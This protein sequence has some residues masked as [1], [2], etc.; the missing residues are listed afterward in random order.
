MDVRLR[1][2]LR[3]GGNL[4]GCALLSFSTPRSPSPRNYNPQLHQRAERSLAGE[5]NTMMY[6]SG[7]KAAQLRGGPRRRNVDGKAQLTT[8]EHTFLG[9]LLLSESVSSTYDL[10]TASVP[11][12]HPADK[13]YAIVPTKFDS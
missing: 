7:R 9:I 12:N 5:D 8:S 11:T 1:R 6:Y 13:T 2:S 10:N 3:E 4:V